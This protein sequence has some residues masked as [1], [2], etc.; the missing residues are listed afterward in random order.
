MTWSAL[1]TF[2]DGSILSAASLNTI[3]QNI[4]HLKGVL[5]APNTPFPSITAT[6]DTTKDFWF[7][8]KL[9]VMYFK[10]LLTSGS[11]SDDVWIRVYD[12]S[13]TLA[14]E[15]F[16]DDNN[17]T[18]TPAGWESSAS[19]SSLTVGT[20]YRMEVHIAFSAGSNPIYCV[21]VEERAS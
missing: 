14:V 12:E 10:F 16:R 3:G 13:S 18:S 20:W 11:T 4:E 9:P 6:S 21:Y 2:A 17:R 7:R 15:V 5:D 19:V 8:H 1:P